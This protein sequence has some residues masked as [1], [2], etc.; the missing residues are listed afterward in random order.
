MA[1]CLLLVANPGVHAQSAPSAAAQAQTQDKPELAITRFYHWY[2]EALAKQ[3]N[4]LKDD[5]Q[6]MQTFVAAPLLAKIDKLIK[7]HKLDADYFTQAQDSFEDWVNTIAVSDVLIS[8]TSASASVTL[9]KTA[10]SRTVL[11]VQLVKEGAGWKISD[12]KLVK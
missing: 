7:S 12:V 1:L 8:A 2:L 9:G 4:P 5:R 6:R 11:T 10:E 3:R